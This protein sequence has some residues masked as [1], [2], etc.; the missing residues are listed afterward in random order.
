M[1]YKILEARIE[2]ERNKLYRIT[3][4]VD[5]TS[6]SSKPLSDVRAISATTKASAGYMNIHPSEELNERLLQRVAAGGNKTDYR[7]KIFPGWKQK[8]LSEL[9]RN[10]A[11]VNSNQ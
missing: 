9:Q 1:D 5:C 3:V 8:Y 7:D 6:G 2:F 11:L 4:L 10:P